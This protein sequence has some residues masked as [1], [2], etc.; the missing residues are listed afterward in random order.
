MLIFAIS[1]IVIG[2]LITVVGV[3]T[4][5]VWVDWVGGILAGI[6]VAS[7]VIWAI[8]C[9]AFTSCSVMRTVQCLLYWIVTVLGPA[10]TAA[11][12]SDGVAC[13]IAGLAT[14]VGWLYINNQLIQIMVYA[15]CEPSKCL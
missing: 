15:N 2:G 4:G 13:G 12:F 9:A 3:C 8:F 5:A 11:G 7:F 10:I 14:W 1:A 6:G